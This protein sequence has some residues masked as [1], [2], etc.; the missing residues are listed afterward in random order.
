MVTGVG[1]YNDLATLMFSVPHET[2]KN[3][4]QLGHDAD[5]YFTVKSLGIHTVSFLT[6][7]ILAYGIATP[8][9]I[10]MPSLMIGASVGAFLGCIFQ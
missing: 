8:G 2:I 6:V 1:Q 5:P 4:L 9:G 10:F 3:L 7:L